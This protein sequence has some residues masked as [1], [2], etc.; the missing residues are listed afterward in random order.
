MLL[1]GWESFTRIRSGRDA[2]LFRSLLVLGDF[3]LVILDHLARELPIERLIRELA[4]GRVHRFLVLVGFRLRVHTE[5]CRD[6][7]PLLRPSGVVLL[8]RFPE[9]PH[10]FTG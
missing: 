6:R 1:K 9:R 10:P 8:E 4:E 2:L 5:L 3:L 7:R